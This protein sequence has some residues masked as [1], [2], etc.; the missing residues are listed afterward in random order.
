[1]L[2]GRVLSAPTVNDTFSDTKNAQITGSFDRTQAKNLA[3]ALRYGALPVALERQQAQEVSATV[4]KDALR[5]GLVA[6][7]L[8][9]AA[10]TIYILLYYKL[11]GAV[12]VASLALSFGLLWS[13]ISWLGNS[14]GLALSLSGVVGI[15]VSIGISIDSNIVYFEVIKEDMHSGRTLRSAADRAFH[16]AMRTIVRADAVSLIAAGLL[17]WLTVGSVRG[18]AFYL[19]LATILDLVA[20]YFFMRPMVHWLSGT[21]L[22]RERPSVFG[23]PRPKPVSEPVAA[24]GVSS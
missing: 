20:S 1:V 2:D 3:T 10:V 19:G 13:I 24:V 6:G 7:L 14:R 9:L 18:F 4:G 11:L 22:A 16:S 21:R 17:Y 12:A 8:G 5:A 15:I 23:I